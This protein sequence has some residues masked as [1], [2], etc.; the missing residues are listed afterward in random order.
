VRDPLLTECNEL[1]TPELPVPGESWACFFDVDGTLLDLAP[2]PDTVVVPPVLPAQLARLGAL[3]GGALALV[4]GRPL[5]DVDRL[6]APLRFPAAGVHGAER[7]FGDGVVRRI[8]FEAARLDPVRQAFDRFTVAH[9]GTLM[10]DKGLGVTLHYRQRPDVAV[11]VHRLGAALIEDLGGAFHLLEGKMVLEIRP[12]AASKGAAVEAF[13]QDTPFVGRRPVYLGDDRTDEDA[14]QVA[15]DLG[16]VSVVVGR[17]ER[18]CAHTQLADVAAVHR[19][20][21]A[22]AVTLQR[23]A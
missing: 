19:W 2:T 8:A 6:F 14:F 9:E 7:R 4:S 13:L 12:A 16:G 15:N 11:E 10:E 21:D 17:P 1:P 20:L 22:V 5:R 3:L 18:T 23:N